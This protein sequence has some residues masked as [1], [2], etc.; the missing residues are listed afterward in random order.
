MNPGKQS[1]D[2]ILTVLEIVAPVF[3]LAAV[4]FAWARMGVEYRVQF[5][6]R[7]AMTLATPCLI[8]TALMQADVAPE[9][10]STMVLAA[11]AAHL[12]MLGVAWAGLRAAGLELRTYLGPFV[13]GNTGNLGLPLA[14]FA[15]GQAGLSLAIVF[16]AVSAIFVFTLGVALVAGQGGWGK[17]AREPIVWATLLGAL[18]LWNGWQTPTFL[19]NTLSLIGQMAIPLLLI[20]LGVALARLSPRN[21]GRAGALALL[22]LV[23]GVGIGWGVGLS[24]GLEGAAFAVLVLQM[25]TPVPVTTYLLAEKYGADADEVA[26]MV[27]ISTLIAVL[28]LPVLL[29]ILL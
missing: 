4:G 1:V 27:V 7:L 8:F 22:K 15:F 26:G 13:F 20:T 29:G 21:F 23:L 2:A 18:F 6:T 5:V 28:S 9:A 12:A 11:V 24:L 10:L 19:T 16:F 3:L 25:S 17:A 14:M